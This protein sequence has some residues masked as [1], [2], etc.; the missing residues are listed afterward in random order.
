MVASSPE[1]RIAHTGVRGQHGPSQAAPDT[2]RPGRKK[3]ERWGP[4]AAGRF[5][6][7]SFQAWWVA[8]SMTDTMFEALLVTQTVVSS[9]VTAM[10]P[11]AVPNSASSASSPFRS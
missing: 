11:D 1:A 9:G 4:L 7:G 2:V 6:D 5:V 8:V 10:P 3:G